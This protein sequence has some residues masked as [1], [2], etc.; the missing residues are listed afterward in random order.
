MIIDLMNFICMY[1]PIEWIKQLDPTAYWHYASHNCQ[2]LFMTPSELRA[3]APQ[4]ATHYDIENG[5]PVFYMTNH[6]GYTM[7][8][9][10]YWYVALGVNID[11]YRRL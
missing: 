4:G 2:D 3:K 5:K 6:L 7:R 9:K 8:Y 11:N 10:G 1:E